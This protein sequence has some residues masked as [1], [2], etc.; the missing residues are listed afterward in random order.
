MTMKESVSGVGFSNNNKNTTL[1]VPN[2]ITILIKDDIL[3]KRKSSTG[4]PKKP[5]K[6]IH[7]KKQPFIFS[8]YS[9]SFLSTANT[10]IMSHKPYDNRCLLP[11]RKYPRQCK[12]LNI[13]SETCPEMHA[14]AKMAKI[15]PK[16]GEYSYEVAKDSL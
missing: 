16:I 6:S 11:N 5:Y 14:L 7:R 8:I 12:L 4:S 2:S 9:I 13:F 3:T 10:C 15:P 1:F